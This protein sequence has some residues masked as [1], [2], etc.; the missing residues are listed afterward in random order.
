MRPLNLRRW[1]EVACFVAGADQT[2]NFQFARFVSFYVLMR[3]ECAKPGNC[4]V[5]GA[6][7]TKHKANIDHTVESC[8]VVLQ[9][10]L[11]FYTLFSY[12]GT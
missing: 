2:D 3:L 5:L 1:Q 8:F 9:L 6:P 7:K 10:H 12:A 4:I 11:I